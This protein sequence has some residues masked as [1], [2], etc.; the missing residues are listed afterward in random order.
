[1]EGFGVVENVLALE[2]PVLL[3]LREKTS[4]LPFCVCETGFV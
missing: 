1:M 4:A 3:A 2:V